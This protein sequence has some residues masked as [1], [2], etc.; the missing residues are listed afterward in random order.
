MNRWL[1]AGV[2]LGALGAAPAQSATE[3]TVND[4]GSILNESLSLP[5]QDTPGVGIGFEE[6]FEFTLPVKIGRAHV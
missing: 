4:V 6:F 3:V 1:L 5:A 2:M